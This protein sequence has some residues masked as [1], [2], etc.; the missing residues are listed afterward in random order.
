MD[1]E[2]NPIKSGT[3]VVLLNGS[4]QGID[5]EYSDVSKW[6]GDYTMNT[7]K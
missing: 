4:S 3:V 5:P 7:Y 6:P 1:E 2:G